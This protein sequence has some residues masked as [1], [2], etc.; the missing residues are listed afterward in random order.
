[1]WPTP[2]AHNAKEGA[3]LAEFKRNTPSLVIEA[4]RRN[5]SGDQSAEDLPN[6]T[7]G[8]AGTEKVKA[9]L[10]P[11]WVEWL[12][13]YPEGYSDTEK[14]EKQS[15][16]EHEGWWFEPD[17][18]RITPRKDLRTKRLK[19]LGNSIVPQ[20]MVEIGKAILEQ[21]KKDAS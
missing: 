16:N 4:Q 5:D 13:G 11:D 2:T 14:T 7:S 19:C 15:I 8:E 18:P 6:T 3:Y 9:N 21:E 12:M 20:I 1:M 17:I 10:N